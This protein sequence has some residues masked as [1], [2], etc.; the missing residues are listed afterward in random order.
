MVRTLIPWNSGGQLLDAVRREMDELV[1]RFHDPE[2]WS[3]ELASFAPRTNI[4]ETDRGYE[5]SIDL[6][7]MN[8]DDFTIELHEG[9]LTVSGHREKEAKEEGKTYHRIER[10]YGKF[11]R[12]FNLGQ[13]VDSEA[14]TAE[15]KDG[16]LHVFVPKTEKAQPKRIQVKT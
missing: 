5:I 4:A 16:V 15:Y 14:V 13:D 12:S 9:R 6:P 8:A 1:G 11:R 3:D 2:A 10:H 7:G